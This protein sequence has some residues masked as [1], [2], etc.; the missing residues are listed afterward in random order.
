[1]PYNVASQPPMSLVT[2]S[3]KMR[4]AGHVARVSEKR[5]ACI[6]LVANLNDKNHL[7]RPRHIRRIILK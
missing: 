7:G 3:R 2:Q 5:N 4:W 6:V 1:M